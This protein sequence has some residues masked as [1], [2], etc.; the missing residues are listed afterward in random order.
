MPTCPG[1]RSPA[2]RQWT[3]GDPAKADGEA[4]A[5]QYCSGDPVG[6]VDESGLHSI[7]VK[8]TYEQPVGTKRHRYK[9]TATNY[10]ES[11]SRRKWKHTGFLF[12]IRTWMMDVDGGGGWQ[13]IKYTH[14]N[15]QL[16]VCQKSFQNIKWYWTSGD[17]IDSWTWYWID[18]DTVPE[19]TASCA[20]PL[21]D[22]RTRKKNSAGTRWSRIYWSWCPNVPAGPDPWL[23][24]RTPKF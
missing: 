11:A 15:V 8:Q 16:Y 22:V 24:K 21:K 17:N 23:L 13:K 3:A 18:N 10:Y 6:G 12:R 7:T 4:S 19:G 20:V 5:W 2:T 1:A 9:L 14:N